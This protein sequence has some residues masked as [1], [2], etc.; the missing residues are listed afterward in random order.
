MTKKPKKYSKLSTTGHLLL[1]EQCISSGNFLCSFLPF[2]A[3]TPSSPSSSK[4][5]EVS[6]HTLFSVGYQVISQS[7][8]VLEGLSLFEIES[9]QAIVTYSILP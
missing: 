6:D 3:L 1:K 2:T 8:A 9:F 4:S 5:S 7:R